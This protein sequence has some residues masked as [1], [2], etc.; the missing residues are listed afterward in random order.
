MLC[1]VNR[2]TAAVVAWILW[3]N[4]NNW[5]WNSVKES[6]NVLATCAMHMVDEWCA[7]NVLLQQNIASGTVLTVTQ[8]QQLRDGWLKCNVDARFYEDLGHMGG[9][10]CVWMHEEGLFQ[11][12]LI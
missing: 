12:V 6:E 5:V 4:R 2:Q 3:N 10:R 1:V 9:D 8:W 11:L 7:M